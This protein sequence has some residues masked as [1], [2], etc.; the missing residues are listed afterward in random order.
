MKFGLTEDF[1]FEPSFVFSTLDRPSGPKVGA[2]HDCHKPQV[3]G[4]STLMSPIVLMKISFNLA[5]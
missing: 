3:L 1:E 2:F 4:I 5:T